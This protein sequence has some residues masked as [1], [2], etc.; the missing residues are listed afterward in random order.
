MNDMILNPDHLY[1]YNF[2]SRGSSECKVDRTIQRIVSICK[3]TKDP[4]KIYSVFGD[5]TG[6]PPLNYT[7]FTRFLCEIYL[8]QLKI[9]RTTKYTLNTEYKYKL[10]ITKYRGGCIESTLTIPGLNR[11]KTLYK[12]Y[13]Y[14]T[15]QD[16]AL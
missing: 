3:V 12:M 6:Q 16:S 2:Y 4:Y 7:T 15:L 13:Q 1:F 8:K 9:M 10:N 5:Y 11:G 14:H